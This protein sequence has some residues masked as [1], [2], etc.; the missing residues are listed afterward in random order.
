M[1]TTSLLLI[2]LHL[3]C[4][5][6]MG[7]LVSFQYIYAIERDL[8]GANKNSYYIYFASIFLA[9]FLVWVLAATGG[10]EKRDWNVDLLPIVSI[11]MGFYL[12]TKIRLIK[13]RDIR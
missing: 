12:P 11:I 8:K 5:S 2:V 4:F 7:G 13:E 9:L 3:F 1:G 10:L 6:A